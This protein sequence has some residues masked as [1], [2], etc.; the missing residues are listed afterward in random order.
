MPNFMR[1]D[2]IVSWTATS[3]D[4]STWT[5]PGNIRP[6]TATR[7]PVGTALKSTSWKASARWRSWSDT[8]SAGTLHRSDTV[9]T[10]WPYVG[11]SSSP[12]RLNHS[13]KRA[14][15]E[16]ILSSLAPR[17]AAIRLAAL[18]SGGSNRVSPLPQRLNR[19]G[20]EGSL[21]RIPTRSLANVLIS[22]P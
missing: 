20:L 8:Q 16:R 14:V 6:S 2:R 21:I 15:I 12:A 18:S 3:S 4:A 19:P 11:A 13:A 9:A 17:I 10:I 5:N 22:R 1:L 7:S